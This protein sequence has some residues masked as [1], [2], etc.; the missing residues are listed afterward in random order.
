MRLFREPKEGEERYK[1]ASPFIIRAVNDKGFKFKF[2]KST[3]LNQR[4]VR[5][6]VELNLAEAT[7]ILS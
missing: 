6:I 7:R 2:Y 1:P 4:W 3:Y 5:E